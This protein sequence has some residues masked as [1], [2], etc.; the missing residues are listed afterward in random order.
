MDVT[1]R[2]AADGHRGS[3]DNDF[4]CLAVRNVFKSP[5][6]PTCPARGAFNEPGYVLCCAGVVRHLTNTDASLAADLKAQEQALRDELR[7]EFETKLAAEVA[8]MEAERE[9][10]ASQLAQ[11]YCLPKLQHVT[12]CFHQPFKPLQEKDMEGF[13]ENKVKELE[14]A[15]KKKEDE[16][17]AAVSLS[18]SCQEIPGAALWFADREKDS[19]IRKWTSRHR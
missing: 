13:D 16:L 12:V 6:S 19:R 15:L 4:V 11:V 1:W 7:K 3:C 18:G 2:E 17:A 9:K 10:L 5:H 8:D 14:A